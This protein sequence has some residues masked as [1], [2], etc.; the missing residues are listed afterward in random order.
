MNKASSHWVWVCTFAT[1]I[2]FTLFMLAQMK[3]VTLAG[4]SSEAIIDRS[5]V[6]KLLVLIFAIA[7]GYN[8]KNTH[9]VYQQSRSNS[10][11]L[12]TDPSSGMAR[13]IGHGLL[14]THS[15]RMQQIYE[16]FAGNEISQSVS[17]GVIRSRLYGREW[18]VRT[19]AQL[20]LTLRF[21]R[22]GTRSHALVGRLVVNDSI[23]GCIG[24]FIQF[25]RSKL[26]RPKLDR[27]K[28][29]LVPTESPRD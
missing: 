10:D 16:G 14:G 29:L 2:L 1:S 22:N 7:L 25:V 3:G 15:Q 5:W 12:R 17:L 8:A 26:D 9:Y 4:F 23:G 21:N 13:L 19:A 28:R 6:S 24:R 11:G 20:L 18:I 27:P